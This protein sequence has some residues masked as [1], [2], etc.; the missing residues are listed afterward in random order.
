MLSK[1]LTDEVYDHMQS[2]YPTRRM[3]M[4]DCGV[5]SWGAPCARTTISGKN[6]QNIIFWL[7]NDSSA[8]TIQNNNI[9]CVV[10]DIVRALTPSEDGDMNGSDAN[11]T[12]GRLSTSQSSPVTAPTKQLLLCECRR[13]GPVSHTQPTEGQHQPLIRRKTC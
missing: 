10:E 9:S 8:Q 13:P 2:T 12:S 11:K 1:E 6:L 3:Q 4:G 5:F 7:E